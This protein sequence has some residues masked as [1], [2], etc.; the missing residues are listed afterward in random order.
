MFTS[1]ISIIN[2]TGKQ[3]H[4]NWAYFY[5][6]PLYLF[7]F[8][9]WTVNWT[10]LIELVSKKSLHITQRKTRS[11]KTMDNHWQNWPKF[12]APCSFPLFVHCGRRKRMISNDYALRKFLRKKNNKHNVKLNKNLEVSIQSSS[13]KQ[14]NI[15]S[16]SFKK[17]LFHCHK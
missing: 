4:L 17:Q 6:K 15:S 11:T 13:S 1:F 10:S 9:R 16:K 3:T 12:C 14:I 8:Y 5:D 7:C 2:L